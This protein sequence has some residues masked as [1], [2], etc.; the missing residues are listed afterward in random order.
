[1]CLSTGRDLTEQVRPPRS[2][3]VNFPMGNAFGAPFDIDMQM[4]V[5]RA[6]LACAVTS[7][8]AGTLVDLPLAWPRLFAFEPGKSRM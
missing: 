4:A 3:F 7:R 2:V 5:L 6:V 1:M 8:V